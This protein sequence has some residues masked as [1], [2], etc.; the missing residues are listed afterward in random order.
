MGKLGQVRAILDKFGRVWTS[1][2][3]SG[4]VWTS[5]DKFGQVWTGLDE[6]GQVWASLGEVLKIE[7]Q[8]REQFSKWCREGSMYLISSVLM[9]YDPTF[10]FEKKIKRHII[11]F[12]RYYCPKV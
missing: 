10:E 8:E 2:D 5:L 4:Q 9:C 6:F 7:K 11:V 1:L 3:E 12:I